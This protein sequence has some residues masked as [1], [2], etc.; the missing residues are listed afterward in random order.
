MVQ[1]CLTGFFV[2]SWYVSTTRKPLELC[3]VCYNEYV[4]KFEGGEKIWKGFMV[5]FF[6]LEWWHLY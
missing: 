1:T 6:V 3:Y 4:T 2:S 5:L